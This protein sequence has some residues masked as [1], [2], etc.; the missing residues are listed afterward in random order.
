VQISNPWKTLSSRTAYENPWIRVR[1]DQVI[2]PDG[3]PGIYG[4]VETRIATGV[5]ALTSSLEVYLVGQYRYAMK[6]YSWEIVEGGSEENEAPL[7]TIRRELQEEA[8]LAAGRILQLGA[9][10]HLS[11]CHSSEVAL[12]YL[13][14]ELSEV[15]SA[16]EGTEVLELQRVPLAQALAMVRR[17]EIK[18]VM[19]IVGLHRAEQYLREKGDL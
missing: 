10:L 5:V 3:T 18:D 15:P 16:P 6:E 8:G 19:S 7:D 14:T 9:E 13:G 12:V 1:E 11:N 4:V 17:G 2:R